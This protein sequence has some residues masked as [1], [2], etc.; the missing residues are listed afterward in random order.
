MAH[1]SPTPGPPAPGSTPRAH[2]PSKPAIGL[3]LSRT[4][5]SG[6][7]ATR[8]CRVDTP[9]RPSARVARPRVLHQQEEGGHGPA[10][11]TPLRCAENNQFPLRVLQ[12]A[13]APARMAAGNLGRTLLCSCAV[14]RGPAAPVWRCGAARRAPRLGTSRPGPRQRPRNGGGQKKPAKQTKSFCGGPSRAGPACAGCYAKG[15]GGGVA[16]S[17]RYNGSQ[18]GDTFQKHY[19][20]GL[21]FSR[22]ATLPI[23]RTAATAAAL[24]A[25]MS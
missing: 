25:A 10:T 21:L 11:R 16:T 9:G 23:V 2:A 20:C 24:R 15:V 1:M 4:L 13:A 18:S 17:P 7:R 6:R 22:A 14:L 3:D 12:A 8:T 19:L 5:W